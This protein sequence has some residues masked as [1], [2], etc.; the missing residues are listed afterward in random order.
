[1]LRAKDLG[2]ARHMH[3][4]PCCNAEMEATESV[5]QRRQVIRKGGE[6]GW[7]SDSPALHFHVKTREPC[8]LVTSR[9]LRT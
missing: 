6:P 8:A 3:A 1:M 9:V 7:L 5:M 4:Y 2:A